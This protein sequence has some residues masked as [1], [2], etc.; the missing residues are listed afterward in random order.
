[1]DSPTQQARRKH[2]FMEEDGGLASI[3]P[4]LES[5]FS[6]NQ[7]NNHMCKISTGSLISRPLYLQRRSSFRN[8]SSSFAS[9]PRFGGRIFYGEARFEEA[10]QPHFLD[11]CFLCRKPLGNRDIFMYRG[12]MPFCSEECRQE[13]IEKDEAKEKSLNLSASMKA[14]RKKDQK[15][16]SS[17]PTKSS[18]QGYSLGTV[19]AA[20]A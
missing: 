13:Q 5:G 15:R 6:E 9:S 19:A 3:V 14:M 17:S 18:P 12:D 20:Y 2:C 11:S 1:M 7:R 4:D 16:S 8:L 10:H